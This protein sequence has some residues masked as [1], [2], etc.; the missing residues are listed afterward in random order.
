MLTSTILIQ[1]PEGAKGV[2]G[3]Q[4]VKGE[5]VQIIWCFFFVLWM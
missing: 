4:G 3:S 1:G 5:K 2:R